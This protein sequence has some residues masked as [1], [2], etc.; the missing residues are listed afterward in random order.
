[1]PWATIVVATLLSFS[2]RPLE[3]SHSELKTGA[4]ISCLF[5]TG[6]ANGATKRWTPNV[7]FE[8]PV[9]WDAG[10]V[11]STV[12][13][14]VFQE[15]SAVP[16]VVPAAGIDVCEM[17]LPVNGQLILEP[18][19]HVTVSASSKDMGGCTGQSEFRY[20]FSKRDLFENLLMVLVFHIICSIRART[21][22]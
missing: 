19:S 15:N 8:D 20:F 11:P 7:D 5:V 13:V 16:I 17:V 2:G 18:N 1:M 4:T 12:D 22:K 21:R 10:R 3:Y 9:N 6:T 14:A